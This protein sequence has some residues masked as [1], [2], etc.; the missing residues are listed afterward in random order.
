M[1]ILATALMGYIQFASCLIVVTFWAKLQSRNVSN[2]ILKF[3]S[4]FGEIWGI[5]LMTPA[6]MTQK[7]TVFDNFHFA[8]QKL[9]LDMQRWIAPP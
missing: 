3:I 4:F 8:Q 1:K 2:L 6:V 5:F 9:P 7:I